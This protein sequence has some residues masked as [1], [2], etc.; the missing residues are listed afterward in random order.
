MKNIFLT[1]CAVFT[2]TVFLGCDFFSGSKANA[3]F[4]KDESYAYGLELGTRLKSE[5]AD[6]AVRPIFND[7]LK[8]LKDGMLDKKTEDFS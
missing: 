2:A 1:I 3:N 4:D 7:F 8:G 6:E 5:L